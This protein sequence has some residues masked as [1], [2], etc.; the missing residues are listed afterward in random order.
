LLSVLRMHLVGMLDDAKG[1]ASRVPVCIDVVDS[2][3]A[4]IRE[5]A[6]S[7]RPTML[8]DLGLAD[9]L[10]WALAQQSKAAGWQMVMEA[11]DLECELAADVQTACF[12]IGQEALANAARHARAT[13]VRLG[14][15]LLGDQLE[16]TVSDNGT[17]FD[18][19][20]FRTPEERRKHFGLMSM[21]ERAGLVGGAFEIDSAPDR[22]TRIRV[23]FPLA[24]GSEPA[25]AAEV[26]D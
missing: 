12:R 1:A 17:G 11:P 19:A 15:K 5:M 8:D 13:E 14:L 6:L 16:L 10:H 7:L 24:Y 4:Q 18:V 22:G 21:E 20:H 26:Y 3:I 25:E 9:A 23:V 2:A